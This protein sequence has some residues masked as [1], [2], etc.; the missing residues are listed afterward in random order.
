METKAAEGKMSLWKRFSYGMGNFGGNMGLILVTSFFLYYCTDSLG[1]SSAVIGTLLMISKVMDGISDILMGHIV[2][3]TH[4]KWGKSRFWLIIC[5]IPFGLCT[6]L[7][8][9]MPHFLVGAGTYVYLFV[10]YVLHSVVF[11]TMFGIS[12]TTLLAYATK[13]SNDRYSMQTFASIL[14][15]LPAIFLSFAT[16]SMVEAFGGGSR[17]WAITAF[18]CGAASTLT[19]LWCAAVVKE[20]PEEELLGEDSAETH[21]LGFVESVKLLFSNKYF[22][23]LLGCNLSIYI[24]T[25]VQGTAGIYFCTYVLNDASSYGWIT[26]AMYAP[27]IVLIGFV[28]PLIS[29]FGARKVNVCGAVVSVLAGLI[30]FINTHSVMC[31]VLSFFIFTVGMLPS[32]ITLQPLVAEA[33]EYTRRKSGKDIT[34]MFYSC[35]S[36]GVK[37]GTGLGTALAGIILS[38][39][40]YDGLASVQTD[41]AIQGILLMFLLTPVIE[42]VILIVLYYLLDVEEVNKR[43]A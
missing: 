28:Q 4:S 43:T 15:I 2:S 16:T 17:G 36:V 34:A 21:S 11:Y 14:G 13:N 27:L 23:V 41:G 20:L 24:C 42:A 19:I 33:S 9:Y 12:A 31:V 7:L 26:L 8:F 22:W 6:F 3:I 38:A 10:I 30:A 40:G 39:C 1:V 37:L 29:R 18:I 32:Y 35:S 5:A 25:G